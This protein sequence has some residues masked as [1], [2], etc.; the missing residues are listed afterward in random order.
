MRRVV[1]VI[2]L[3][4]VISVLTASVAGAEPNGPKWMSSFDVQQFAPNGPKHMSLG[5]IPSSLL[6][7][8]P[9]SVNLHGFFFW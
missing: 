7:I 6:H 3:A 2:L 9:G 5:R 8:L 1:K 4:L